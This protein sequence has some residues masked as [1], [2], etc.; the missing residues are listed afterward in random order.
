MR[1]GVARE[2]AAAV[3]GEDLQVRV[4][5]QHA[6]EDQV[7]QR[8][9]RLQRIADDV[10][11]VEARQALGVRE[12]VGVDDDQRAQLLGLLPERRE[13][14]VGQLAAVDVGQHLHALEA[15]LGDAAL[16]LLG[17]LVAVGHR[18]GAEALEAV[19]LAARRTRRCR[20]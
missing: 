4:A 15:E 20:R 10:V 3:H 13:G 1:P 6:V 9:R 5:L 11:E 16:Q 17:R 8:N 12:A 14:R 2:I 7:V 18:H 19:G